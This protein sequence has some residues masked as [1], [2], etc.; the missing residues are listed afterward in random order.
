MNKAYV[1][2]HSADFDGLFSREIARLALP[3]AEFIGWD[4]GQPVPVIPE[5]A[6]LYMIDI[7]VEGLMDFPGLTWIDHHKSAMEK[8]AGITPQPAGLRIDGVAACRLAW[9]WF[10]DA[11]KAQSLS[12]VDF[13]AHR[14]TE[15]LAVRLAGEY[16]VFNHSD[17]RSIILQHGL[18]SRVLSSWHWDVLLGI[19]GH[20]QVI[21]LMNELLASG[22]S[23][24]FVKTEENKSI[25]ESAGFTVQFES[26]TFLACNN[27]RYN[28]QLFTAGIKPEHDGLLGFNWD[29]HGKWRI[30]MY[31]VPGKPDI[32]FSKIASKHGGGGHRQACGFKCETLPFSPV[33][34]LPCD[35]LKSVADELG[36]TLFRFDTVVEA[37]RQAVLIGGKPLTS[38]QA[39]ENAMAMLATVKPARETLRK[40]NVFLD[41]LPKKS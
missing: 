41:S 40:V 22:D 9:Q 16:D 17:P 29:G 7:S 11:I 19:H 35:T 20:E 13:D 21:Q 32:D 12:K 26:L 2:Y 4:Y 18:R 31:G 38:E 5:G 6:R 37:L 23:I 36:N 33:G 34:F 30:S 24:A 39:H 27:G 10:T 15:P 25:I 3:D 14:V 1:I 28:S 8:Y